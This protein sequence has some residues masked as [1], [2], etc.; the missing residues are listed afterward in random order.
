VAPRLLIKGGRLVDPARGLDAAGDIL[1]EGDR[2]VRVGP[3]AGSGTARDIAVID[4]T[5]LVVTPGLIDAHTHLREPGKAEE[6][7]ILSG[8]RAAVAGGITSVACFPNT[9]PA[10]DNEAAAEFVVLQGKRAGYAN[11]FPVGAVTQNRDGTR[12][13]EIGGLARAGAVA[14]SD[15]DRSIESAEILRRGLAYAN[16]FDRIVV[17]H[18]EDR[19]LRGSGVMNQGVVSVRLGLSG[20]PNAAE[21]IVVA[22]DLTLAQITGGRLHIGQISTAG[23]VE[24][25]RQAKAKGI[26]ATGESTP[27]HFTLTD[28]CLAG[29]DPNFKMLPPLRSAADLEAVV[30]GLRDGTIDVIAT[31]HAPHA[32]EEKA[33]EFDH[34]PFGVIGLETMFPVAYSELV[35]RH[36]IPLLDVIRKMTINPARILSLKERGSLEEG[37]IA[38]IAAFD[39][40]R[41]RRIDTS[42]FQSKSRNCPFDGREVR[43]TPIHVVVGGRPVMQDG[44]IR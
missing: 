18:C 17:S 42:R 9:E 27:H 33:V 6:E 44:S 2:I 16:M 19:T 11:V 20:I 5:G 38:D 7:T 37:K 36:R 29:Y 23:A 30:E 32:P 8:A 14:F 40:E 3:G 24:L 31:G 39:L 10:I 41:P 1:V 25:L 43:G 13:A 28:E 12:L 34:A 22:R 15:A 26:R 21:D 35:L 4:A